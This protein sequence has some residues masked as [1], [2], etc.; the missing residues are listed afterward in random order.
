M[1]LKYVNTTI[2]TLSDDRFSHGNIYPVVA[3]PNGLAFFSIQTRAHGQRW[4]YHPNDRSF[5]GIRLTHQPSPWIGDYGHFLLLPHSGDYQ[6]N[7]HQR[8]SSFD[9]K[10]QKITPYEMKGFLNRY[11]ID[12]SLTPSFSGAVL[13]LKYHKDDK[14]AL[15]IIGLDGILNCEKIDDYNLMLT[16][17]AKVEETNPKIIEYILIQ[18]CVPLDIEKHNNAYTIYF[19]NDQVEIKIITS[20]I[21]FKQAKINFNRELANK[22]YEEI[23]NEAILSWESRLSKIEII[24][25]NIELMNLFYSAFYRTMLFPRQFHEFDENDNPIHLAANLGEV[26]NGVLYVDNGYWD[27]FRTLYPLLSIVEP[28]LYKNILDGN[29]NY[30]K[31]N[32]YFPKWTCPNEKEIMTGTLCEVT[33]A[34]GIVKGFYNQEEGQQIVK[35]LIK[36]AEVEDQKGIYGRKIPNS[37][38]QLTYLP[39]DKVSASL[40]ESLDYYY[41]DYSIGLAASKVGLKDISEKYLSFSLNYRQLFSKKEGF[42]RSKDSKGNFGLNFNQFDWGYDYIEGG[43]WQCA[44][45]VFHDIKGLDKLYDYKLSEKIDELLTTKPKFNVGSYGNEI[46]E[47]SE[48]AA[49]GFGQLAL[50]NQPSFHIPFIYAELGNIKKTHELVDQIVTKLFKAS[51]DGFPG[52]ED[53][54][55][56]SAWLIFALLGFYPLNPASGVYT[57]SGPIVD[58][59]IINLIDKKLIIEKKN[60]DINNLT[61]HITHEE[62]I[63]GG[64]LIEKLKK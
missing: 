62:L 21:S 39:S 59:A 40:S 12:Y 58:K 14:K 10:K 5:E 55:S 43:P 38:R 42:L 54:G 45:S 49:L 32:G 28:S 11:L 16:T 61:T 22:T 60:M 41:S 57:V 8:W 36:N 19:L 31:E 33:M 18:T 2:G 52:D 24:D 56:M 64:K 26:K 27:T 35:M 4:W 29:I 6:E 1:Y 63:C 47:M 15:S 30:F 34:E 13:K 23:K 48:M 50:S 20:F 7:N 53:N 46:H 51:P 37:Y 25:D 3:R 17:D 44:F 9:I